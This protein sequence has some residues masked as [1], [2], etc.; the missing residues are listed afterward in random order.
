MAFFSILTFGQKR[1]ITGTYSAPVLPKLEV[2]FNPDSTFW[3]I[4]KQQHPTF[5]R[6]EDFEEK[7]RWS[8]NGDTIVLNPQLPKKTYV[9]W[10]FTEARDASDTTIHLSFYHIKRYFDADGNLKKSDTGNIRQLDYAFNKLKKRRLTRVTSGP[11]SRCAFAGYIPKEIITSEM[12]ISVPKPNEGVHSIFIGC[13]EL[14][15]T[16]EFPI[17]D[18][19]SNLLVLNV[20]SNYYQDGQIRQLKYLIKNENVLYTRQQLNGRFEKDTIWSGTQDR[21]TRKKN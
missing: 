2:S 19:L 15:D 14:Q 8:L 12:T 13:Y 5:Y 9:E 20:Y 18:S 1:M 3:Y 21:L 7:G 17:K 11:S 16:K 4:T 6:W 10:T